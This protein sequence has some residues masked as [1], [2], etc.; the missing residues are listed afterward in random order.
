[1]IMRLL[2]PGTKVILAVEW[3]TDT[4]PEE[5]RA[6]DG[7]IFEVETAVQKRSTRMYTL[8][9]CKSKMGVP[10]TILDEWLVPAE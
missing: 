8:K 5:L 9:G 7:R 6:M 10:F 2:K 1:M 4:M 3:A